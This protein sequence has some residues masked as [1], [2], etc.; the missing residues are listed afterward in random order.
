[1]AMEKGCLRNG[2]CK[3]DRCVNADAEKVTTTN[4]MR[5]NNAISV[6]TMDILDFYNIK[7]VYKSSSD[8]HNM[9]DKSPTVVWCVLY[10]HETKNQGKRIKKEN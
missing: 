6:P 9:D 7:W 4:E 10:Q 5:F 8:I 3:M 2:A 1:M